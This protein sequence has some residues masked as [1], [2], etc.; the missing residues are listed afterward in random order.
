MAPTYGTSHGPFK[1]ETDKVNLDVAA[2]CYHELYRHRLNLDRFL[3]SHGSSTVPREFVDMIN[4]YGGNLPGTSG[5]SEGLLR[6]VAR[7]YNKLNIDTDLRLDLTAKLRK[8]FT[9]RPDIAEG[10][11]LV[12]CMYAI[13]TGRIRAIDIKSKKVIPSEKVTDPRNWLQEINRVAPDV[14]RE[15]YRKTEDEKFIE[16]MTLASD[17]FADHVAH[18]SGDVFGG[19]GLA[20]EVDTSMTL[21][22]MAQSYRKK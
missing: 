13:M 15:D 8:L 11:E 17:S 3:V 1:G 5:M 9:E 2:A 12:G 7:W 18:L 16:V 20:V 21:E 22:K 19:K 14:L 10:S 4:R 6:Q